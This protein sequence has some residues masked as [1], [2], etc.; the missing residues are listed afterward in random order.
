M[1]TATV[2][3]RKWLR[4]LGLGLGTLLALGLALLA[5]TPLG[6]YL[7]RA[8]WEEGKIL[9]ARRPIAEV[10]ADPT[11][12]AEL[13]DKLAL[14]LEARAFAA[15]SLGF[16]VREAFTQF[17]QLERDTLV[18]V[19]SG[20]RRDALVP[21]LWRY[22]LV[23]RLPYKGFFRR[24]DALDARQAL[25]DE[26]FDTYLRP[27]AAFSTLGWFNDPLLST[28]A[29]ADST[30]LVNTVIHE[31]THN[32]VFIPGDATFNESFANFVGARGAEWFF[33][34]RG[35][36]ANAL[37]AAARWADD[38]LLAGFWQRLYLSMDSAF[39][40]NPGDPARG[41][42]MAIRDSM[43]T[44]ARTALVTEVGPRLRTIPAQYAARV[45]LDNAA[46]L[47]RRVYL[48]GIEEFEAALSSSGGRL[49]AAIAAI[50]T[51]RE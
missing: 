24:G 19:L 37:R 40:A 50:L 7:V 45:P 47:A 10:V 32:R 12:S 6:R 30:D 27:A 43:Y 5:A 14:V 3:W 48:S 20:A 23:G 25:E 33:L 18:L 38:Q 13:R 28:T 26:D 34:T 42:R 44:A 21:K 36:S 15:D 1:T 51:T 11:V 4:R 2:G 39:K 35:D 41:R 17:T 22:P 46:L 8:G 29:R 9:A 16:P 31:I 49:P